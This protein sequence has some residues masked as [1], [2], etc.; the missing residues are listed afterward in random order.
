LTGQERSFGKLTQTLCEA[1][2]VVLRR[3][4]RTQEPMSGLS[5]RPSVP[6]E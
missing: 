4:S 5:S 3:T 2:Y 6:P 1:F